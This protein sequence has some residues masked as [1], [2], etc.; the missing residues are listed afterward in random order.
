[1]LRI[2]I[3]LKI[4]NHC[5]KYIDPVISL[6]VLDLVKKFLT[7]FQLQFFNSEVIVF[8]YLYEHLFRF[9]RICIT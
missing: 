4:V 5:Q 9:N 8:L 7:N 3:T 1:M 6:R 2:F